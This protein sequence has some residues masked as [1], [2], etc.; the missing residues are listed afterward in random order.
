MHQNLDARLVDV[1]APAILV[2]RA[3][4]RLDV[5]Q[6]ITLR[7]EGPYG[8]AE[9]RGAAEP[10]AHRYLEAGLAGPVAVHAQADVVDLHR[11]AV[12]R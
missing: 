11:R 4:D 5:A 2:V 7:Q 12:V 10:A 8:L 9:E 1:V 3:H 6:Q